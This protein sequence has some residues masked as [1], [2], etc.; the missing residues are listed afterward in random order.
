MAAPSAFRDT[1]YLICWGNHASAADFDATSWTSLNTF[2][3]PA[4]TVVKFNKNVQRRRPFRANS[5][6]VP[7]YADID[8]DMYGV[9]PTATL[10]VPIFYPSASASTTDFL[11]YLLGACIQDVTV[12]GT[13][14]H[15]F[16]PPTQLSTTPDFG[17]NAG[18]YFTLIEQTGLAGHDQ[19]ILSCSAKEFTL[20]WAP[21][22][23]DGR[24]YL[25][26]NLFG[27]Y[28]QD[29]ATYS[30]SVTT[31]S[32]YSYRDAA[33]LKAFSIGGTDVPLY[34]FTFTS[35]T[36]LKGVPTEGYAAA[37]GHNEENRVMPLATASGSV[38]VLL[39]ADTR[40]LME[41]ENAK[42]EKQIIVQFSTGDPV[43]VGGELIL[44]ANAVFHDHDY[45]GTEEQRGTLSFDCIKG[46]APIYSL[47]YFTARNYA[48]TYAAGFWS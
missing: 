6:R 13:Y 23:N 3:L 10:S 46:G 33:S 32:G 25:T 5:F 17:A 14:V 15:T 36:G 26:I 16:T 48:T 12:S 8:N 45:V 1:R 7:Q 18:G 2:E 11:S 37:G 21:D 30:G 41:T 27:R 9:A 31:L 35:L 19:A 42:S 38:D 29:G 28:H 34:G 20:S 4:E 22:K 24:L 39:N 44:K 47:S 43:S 40:A